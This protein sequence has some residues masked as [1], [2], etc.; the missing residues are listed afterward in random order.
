MSHTQATEGKLTRLDIDAVLEQSVRSAQP[1]AG[2]SAAKALSLTRSQMTA[3][4]SSLI[5]ASKETATVRPDS[6]LMHPSSP[7]PS[8]V[9]NPSPHPPGIPIQHVATS[10]HASARGLSPLKVRRLRHSSNPH[11]SSCTGQLVMTVREKQKF[12]RSSSWHVFS[13]P[14]ATYSDAHQFTLRRSSWKEPT[15]STQQ[16]WPWHNHSGTIVD[17][18]PVGS[19]VW[20]ISHH[21]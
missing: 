11:F 3:S 15:D 19:S 5:V 20:K 4:T 14:H 13:L 16:H 7:S 6:R 12:L 17:T 1:P 2:Q 21:V 8:T 9:L 18:N 10:G